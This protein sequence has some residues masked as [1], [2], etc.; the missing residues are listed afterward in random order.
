MMGITYN[1]SSIL[2]FSIV[3]MSG[4]S[5]SKND[6]LVSP[7]PDGGEGALPA[8][9]RVALSISPFSPL[10][11]NAGLSFSAG[12]QTADDLL[13]LQS[14]YVAHGA[15]EVYARIA[16]REPAPEAGID[17]SLSAG[18]A[19]ATVANTL[20]LPLNVELGLFRTYG[21]ILCQ[22]PPDF[23]DYTN[24]EVPGEWHTLTLG[25]MTDA[26]RQYGATVATRILATGVT[27]NYW[28][29][30]NEI[31][32]GTAGVAPQPFPGA[33]DGDEG[34]SD[35]YRAPDVVNPE[36]GTESVI[37]LLTA[38]TEAERIAWLQENVWP[39]TAALLLATADG[40]RSVDPDARFATHISTATQPD[41]AEAFYSAMQGHGFEP[42]QLGLSFYPS[43]AEDPAQRIQSFKTT[44]HRLQEV[45]DKPIFLAEFAYPGTPTAESG[46]FNDWDNAVEGYPLT[47][48]G[49][50]DLVRDMGSWLVANDVVGIRP[51]APDLI[52][53]GWAPFALFAPN[54]DGSAL[55]ARSALSA[56]LDGLKNPDA[57][58]LP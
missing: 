45:F 37:S 23:S 39:S 14:L 43:S 35:W 2:L 24:I 40:I 49:Q 21:D 6:P 26:L 30:G 27:V 53:A 18:M 33:C 17:H 57:E 19:R 54:E 55:E 20:S 42:D 50:A 34:A 38:F 51:W 32:F 10:M 28:N 44:V 52:V 31:D 4:C 13:S 7:E 25:E 58:A 5:S 41:F 56:L 22:T 8:D 29:L 12:E 16:T 48:T 15:T 3:A 11:L 46:P 36:I 9:F 47:E 1:F